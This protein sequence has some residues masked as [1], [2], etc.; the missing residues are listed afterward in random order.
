MEIE[1][2]SG[3]R[4][5]LYFDITKYFGVFDES[6]MSNQSTKRKKNPF[7]KEVSSYR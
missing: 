3:K 2:S 6:D 5:T 4:L 1:L 7:S